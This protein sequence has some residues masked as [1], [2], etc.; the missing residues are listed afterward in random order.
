M[1]YNGIQRYLQLIEN[2]AKRGT[3]SVNNVTKQA[4]TLSEQFWTIFILT[5]VICYQN[6]LAWSKDLYEAVDMY[7]HI[8]IDSLNMIKSHAMGLGNGKP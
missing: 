7:K 3:S 2:M 8:S 6:T 5:H 4:S 1:C